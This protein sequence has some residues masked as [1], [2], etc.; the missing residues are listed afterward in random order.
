M[1][2]RSVFFLIYYFG[3]STFIGY[4]HAYAS[5]PFLFQFLFSP[6]FC[7]LSFLGGV[8]VHLS[9]MSFDSYITPFSVEA[10]ATRGQAFVFDSFFFAIE[11]RKGR[12][13]RANE[14]GKARYGGRLLDL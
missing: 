10:A 4:V 14:E 6:L 8:G 9:F 7:L 13:S 3:V 2:F 12:L 5:I 11:G 1:L